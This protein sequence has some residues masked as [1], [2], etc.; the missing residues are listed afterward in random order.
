MVLLGEDIGGQNLRP[1][2][3]RDLFSIQSDLFVGDAF[4]FDRRRTRLLFL[5]PSSFPMLQLV[6]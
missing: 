4:Y 1:S 2:G 5:Q 6:S 3:K